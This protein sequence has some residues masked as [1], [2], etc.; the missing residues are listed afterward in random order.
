MAAGLQERTAA[1]VVV[2]PIQPQPRRAPLPVV[3]I[4]AGIVLVIICRLALTDK[5]TLQLD[6]AELTSLQLK[7]NDLNTWVGNNQNTSWI[8]VHFFNEIRVAIAGLETAFEHTIAQTDVGSGAPTIGWLGVTVLATWVAFALGNSKVAVLTAAGV[9]VIG[10]QGLWTDAMETLSLTLASVLVA[11]IFG[12]PLG[13]WAGTNDRVHKIITP[14]LDFMQT[15]PSYVYL[16]P[17]ALVFS[18]GPAAAVIAT[19]IFAAPPTIRITAYGIRQ[20]PATTRE[21]ADS[22]GV[23]GR[24]R[25]TGVLLPMAKKSI[26]LGINQTVMAA[27]SMVTIA[28]LIAAPGLGQDVLSA[29]QSLHVGDAFNSGLAI[30]IMGIVLDRVT[31]A[32]SVRAERGARSTRG[33]RPKVRRITLGVGLVVV[34]GAIY[35]SHKYVWAST[36]P[37]TG[38]LGTHITSGVD[39]ASNW[40]QTNWHG[41]TS[42]ITNDFSD[43]IL[44]PFQDLLT[45]TPWFVIGLLILLIAYAIGGVRPT[46]ISAV[47]LALMAYLG[48]WQDAMV[49]LVCTLLATVFVM[50]LGVAV[51][52]WMGRSNRADQI[53]RPV[54]DAA[55]TMPAFVYLV[56]VLGLFG[57]TRFTA[58]IA[59]V[60]FAAPVAVKVIADGISSVSANTIEAATSTGSTTWQ[61]ITRVQLPMAS[62]SLALATNQGLIYVLSMVVVGGL[63]G[64]GALGYDVVAGFAQGSLF[65]KGLAAGLTIVLMGVMLDRITQ[66]AAHRSTTSSRAPAVARRLPKPVT[67]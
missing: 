63:V 67:V 5:W 14:V 38:V 45:R 40:V 31:T 59:A 33:N 10:L 20:V 52:V 17:L 2:E 19:V 65:G 11:L 29:L 58:I 1:P 56:P 66:A 41:A 32:A 30:V 8:F 39:G 62:K 54:L 53:I 9:V 13:I 35:E 61:L 37:G 49:T 46:I 6:Q 55:Q 64:G 24:Q 7:F 36:F 4:G 60:I 48:L 27:L 50:I 34:V 43:W 44:N 42:A 26:V 23:N 47:C 51:G 22:L 21:A 25:L 16:S 28:A 15:M 12:I 57:A 18:I 3:L